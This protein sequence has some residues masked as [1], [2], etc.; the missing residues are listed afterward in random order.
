M[1]VVLWAAVAAIGGLGSVVRFLADAFVARRTSTGFPLGTLAVNV[2]GSLALGVVVG[3]TS[4]ADIVLLSGT[5]AIGSYTTFATWM[6]ETQ[7][8]GEERQSLLAAG[9]LVVSVILG[10]AAAALGRAIGA[11]L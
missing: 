3:A 9:N 4:G 6:L 2:T 8:L 7:R 11:S 1:S 10:V 5:S